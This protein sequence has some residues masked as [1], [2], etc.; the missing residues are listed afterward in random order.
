MDAVPSA[1]H[2]DQLRIQIQFAGIEYLCDMCLVDCAFE[3]EGIGPLVAYRG[4]AI[5]P[6][7]LD[8]PVQAPHLL[9]VVVE[10]AHLIQ[11]SCH[12]GFEH[13]RGEVE[14]GLAGNRLFCSIC[15][16]VSNDTMTVTALRSL[17]ALLSRR[18]SYLP[19]QLA[20]SDPLIRAIHSAML[21]RISALI[22]FQ[23]PRH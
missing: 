14:I 6:Q 18:L 10:F 20:I 2:L 21:A 1:G 8:H 13:L 12:I 4:S 15:T 23:R 19:I 17:I 11:Q 9:V 16:A 7:S 22:S 5:V 3:D